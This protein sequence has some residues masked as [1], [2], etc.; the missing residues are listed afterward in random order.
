M[1]GREEVSCSRCSSSST[2]LKAEEKEEENGDVKLGEQINSL[3]TFATPPLPFLHYTKYKV[4]LIRAFL[5]LY[6]NYCVGN[7]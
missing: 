5:H 3:I 6:G 1:N 2:V 7:E 4:D